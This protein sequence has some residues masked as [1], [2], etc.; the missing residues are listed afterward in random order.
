MSLAKIDVA[1]ALRN[2][3]VDPADAFNFGIEWRGYTY[4]ES[5]VAFGWMH[6]SAAYQILS[7]AIAFFMKQQGHKMF[8][9]IDGYILVTSEDQ[10]EEAFTYLSRLLDELGLPMNSDKKTP[11]TKVMTC[12]GIRIDILA[13]TLSIDAQKLEAVHKECIQIRHKK[14][15]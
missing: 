12:L 3:R 10:A 6:G 2:L 5:A 13:N 7:D 14:F 1:R 15:L 8:P 11:P 4:L 9:Y